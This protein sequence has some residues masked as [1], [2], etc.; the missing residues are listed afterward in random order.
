MGHLLVRGAGAS[1]RPDRAFQ[2]ALLVAAKAASA[3][4]VFSSGGDTK[5]DQDRLKNR[6]LAIK[7]AELD[8]KN[9]W[10]PGKDS[11]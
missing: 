4:V 5:I 11:R 2:D 6:L 10:I 7:A 9:M 8:W 3:K 1:G